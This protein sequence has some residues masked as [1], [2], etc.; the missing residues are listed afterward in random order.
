[1]KGQANMTTSMEI[2]E[3]RG[4]DPREK[5]IHELLDKELKIIVLSS[6]SY[7]WTQWNEIREVI[8]KQN[9]KF[10]KE[11]EN[12]KTQAEILALKNKITKLKNSIET[13]NTITDHS[14]ERISKIKDR[15]FEIIWLEEPKEK[16]ES[17]SEKMLKWLME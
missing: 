15:V 6:M 12:K 2:N 10:K 13:F 8:H 1:M 7:K 3:A 17:E 5:E 9:L 11:I 4:T 16:R 14:G